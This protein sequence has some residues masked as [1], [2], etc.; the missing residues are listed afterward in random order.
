[1]PQSAYS[2]LAPTSPR[3]NS[4][5]MVATKDKV[6]QYDKLMNKQIGV[7]SRAMLAKHPNI[8]QI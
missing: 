7:I 1:M 8:E 4:E 2:S 6:S 5:T 3:L